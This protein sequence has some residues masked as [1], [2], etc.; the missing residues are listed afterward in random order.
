MKQIINITNKALKKLITIQTNNNS[1][2]ILFSAKSG[3]CSGFGYNLEPI[4]DEPL[5]ND[6]VID[7]Y[8]KDLNKTLKL[9][10]CGRSLLYLFGTKI[11]WK[12]DFMGSRF[13]FENPTAKGSC[14][15]GTSFS[16]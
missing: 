15:C 12:E 9:N 5:K 4:N 16:I 3:G 10:V 6:E 11:D 1:K 7:F 8:D 14:G 2:F 13:V